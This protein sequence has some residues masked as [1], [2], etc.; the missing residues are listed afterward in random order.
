[1]RTN[2]EDTEKRFDSG[3]LDAACHAIGKWAFHL[4]YIERGYKAVGGEYLLIPVVY[5]G[6]WK[7]INYLFDSLEEL[8]NE[9][10]CRKKRSRGTARMR[11]YR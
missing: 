2:E 1:M 9:R 5:W 10:N 11:N 4:A 7:A 3:Y 6:A 8:E